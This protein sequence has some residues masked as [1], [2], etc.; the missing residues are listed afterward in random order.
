M[1]KLDSTLLSPIDT[2]GFNH[3]SLSLLLGMSPC[4][5]SAPALLAVGETVFVVAMAGL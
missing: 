5:N 4:L 1:C 2:I 3:L